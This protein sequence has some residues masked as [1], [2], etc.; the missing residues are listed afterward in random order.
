[1]SKKICF[2]VT[3][4]L[5]AKNFFQWSFEEY[6][7]S[8]Y[9]I[10]LICDMDKEYMD[11]LPDYV[12][13][14]PLPMKRGLDFV[15]A[16]QAIRKMTKMFKENKFDIIEYATPNASFYASIAAKR[17]KVP[18]R[19]YSQLGLVYW[20]FSGVKR[21]IF[22]TIERG[23]CKRST[24]VQP[25]SKGNLDFCRSNGFYTKEKSRIVWNGSYNGIDTEKFD[26]SKKSLYRD[27]I[28]KK[29]NISDETILLGFLG[30]VGKDKG[31]NELIC[32]FKLL[33]KKYNV[34]LLFVGYNERSET[35]EQELFQYF[36]NCSDIIFTDG[37]VDDPQK[38]LSAMDIFIFPSY[39]E[40]FG[41]VVV[42]AEAMGVPVVVS[43]I[44]G[45][46]NGMVEGVT[47]YKV[48]AREVEQL[49]EKTSQLIENPSLRKQ[50]GEAGAKFAVEN[51]NSKVLIKKIIENRDWL[52]SRNK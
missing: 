20:S 24:D 10:T 44:P 4:A 52:I 17:A 7:N 13:R 15:G 18:V 33:R 39:R 12:H 9:D 14:Y 46:Q 1:M 38:Y 47:G 35:V 11:S 40:G 29:Y 32:S 16:L 19:L 50:F 48:P 2:V 21:K 37:W 31:F 3:V 45:P 36:M 26:Y 30:R 51:F 5:A 23:V 27:E 43:D 34:K 42:E 28:R 41:N 25:D 22:E 49:V 6:H 8:G